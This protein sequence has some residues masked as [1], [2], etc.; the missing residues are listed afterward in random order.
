M[1]ENKVVSEGLWAVSKR[2]R[3]LGVQPSARAGLPVG[4]GSEHA[5]RLVTGRDYGRCHRPSSLHRGRVV[6]THNAARAR[7]VAVH[8]FCGQLCGQAGGNRCN[9]APLRAPGWIAANLGSVFFLWIKY[10]HD[11][12]NLVTVVPCRLAGMRWP[13]EFRPPVCGFGLHA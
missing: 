3:S 9:P 8:R 10:L 5:R 4:A 11:L 1:I 7:A 12:D 13:V 2:M 6:A